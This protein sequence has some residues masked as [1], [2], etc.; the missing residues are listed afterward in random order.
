MRKMLSAALAVF[1][2]SCVLS[3][4]QARRPAAETVVAETFVHSYGVTLPEEEWKERGE[5]GRIVSLR[6]DGVEVAKT[7]VRGVLHGECSYSFPHKSTPAKKEYYRQGEL[8][9]TI[10]FY[11]SGMP[12]QQVTYQG[13]TLFVTRWYES[14]AP[15]AKE[16][17]AGDA[18]QNGKYLDLSQEVEVEVVHGEG[19]RVRRDGY[20]LLESIDQISDGAMTLSTTYHPNGTPASIT[21]YLQGVVEGQRKTFS[22]AGDPLSIEAWVQ[23]KQH[24]ITLL[25]ENGAKVS[26]MPYVKGK[27]QG[28]EKRY[29]DESQLVQEVSWVNN[30]RHGPTYSYLGGTTQI[31]WYFRDQEVSKAAYDALSNQ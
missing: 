3:S 27:R 14:G 12:K 10:D 29:R 28:V 22:P 30:Q 8:Y 15:Q 4:C 1:V 9:K 20:G 19:K 24:G 16:E 6:Q 25:F 11:T 18:L 17:M 26:E 7:Y 5:N 13:D 21:P 2:S 23:G 31:T